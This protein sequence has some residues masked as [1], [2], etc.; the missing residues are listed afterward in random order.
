[1]KIL[2]SVGSLVAGWLLVVPTRHV[3]ALAELSASERIEFMATTSTVRDKVR[4]QFGPTVSFEHGPATEK[5]SA[6]C[7]VDHA[8]LHIVPT[9]A[10]LLGID[11]ATGYQPSWTEAEWPWDAAAAHEAGLDYLYFSDQ[12]DHALVSVGEDIPS[13]FFRRLIAKDLGH[14]RWDWK[15]HQQEDVYAETVE[16]LRAEFV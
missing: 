5:R 8:H 15:L 10:A 7:G 9:R 11:S 6:G 3:V 1:M 2:P 4:Q 12:S 14:D 16:R 13:Q